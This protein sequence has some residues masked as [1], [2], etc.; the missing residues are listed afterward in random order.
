[1]KTPGNKGSEGNIMRWRPWVMC[2]FYG[3]RVDRSSRHVRGR[4]GLSS[5]V[6]FA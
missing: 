2:M 3:D 6:E 4:K 5:L 1:M